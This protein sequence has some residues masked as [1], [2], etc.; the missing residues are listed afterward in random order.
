MHVGIAGVLLERDDLRGAASTWTSA[1]ASATTTGCR[2]TRTGGG[3]PRPG[4]ARPKATSTP[5]SSSST[6]RTASTT[7]TTSRTCGRFPRCGHGCGCGAASST[8]R[9]RGRASGSCPRTTSCPTCASSSTSPWRGSCSPGTAAIG[10]AAALE[11][12]LGLLQRLLAAA[13]DGGRDGSVLEVLILQA[14]AQ[15]ARGDLAA[16][17]AAL[18]RAVTLAQPEG[19]V[20][21]FADEGPPMAALLKALTKQ[22]GAPGYVRRLLAAT[23]RTEHHDPAVR[24][25]SSSR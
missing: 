20:R 14:L 22:S 10:T 15:Q 16:A 5:R 12:A 25:G 24:Q 1:V 7:A 8:R 11:D 21:L 13:Q 3:S 9:R 23:T 17:L 19:Y 6:R 4:C 18:Q 2:R